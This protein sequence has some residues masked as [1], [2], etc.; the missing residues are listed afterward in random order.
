MVGQHPVVGLADERA[1]DGRHHL[2]VVERPER[3]ARLGLAARK[4]RSLELEVVPGA[5]SD[6]W[7]IRTSSSLS[8]PPTPDHFIPL[9]YIAGLADAADATTDVLIDGYAYGSLSMACYTLGAGC[10]DANS[11]DPAATIPPPQ[12]VPLDQSNP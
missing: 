10:P 1:E 3:L 6:W 11:E 12:D 9:L 2:A 7:S 8:R 4:R 5:C